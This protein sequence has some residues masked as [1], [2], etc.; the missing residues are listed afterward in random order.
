MMPYSRQ[1]V[2][3]EDISAVVDVLKSNFLTQ[4][5]MVSEFERGVA[6]YCGVEHAVATCNATAALHLAC[7]ALGVAQ[8]DVVWVAAT[9]FVASANCA[10][11]CGADI[12]FVDIDSR[13]GL[14]SVAALAAKFASYQQQGKPL[15]KV[16]IVVHIAG[17]SCDM[18]ALAALCEPLNIAII[19]DASH[20]LGG[21]YQRQGVGC[22]LYS[23]CSVFSFHPV[24]PIT[25]GEGGM[26]VSQDTQLIKKARLL[27]SHGIVKD[28]EHCLADKPG[29]WYYEQQQLGFNY[30]LSDIHAALGVS[31]LK[32]LDSFI[33]RKQILVQ[34]YNVAFQHSAI[35]PLLVQKDCSSAW[36]LYIVQFT[37]ISTRNRCFVALR[38]AGFG[39]NLHYLPIPGHPYYRNLGFSPDDYPNATRYAETSLSLPLFP[40]MDA[41]DVAKVAAICLQCDSS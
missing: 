12:D 30:R 39:V 38:A 24:K 9:S 28:A 41:A 5:P 29:E 10:L 15:P 4:G 25:S 3:D 20:A 11:Y 33:S 13:T 2:A 40:D 21:T 23:A 16:L 14:I 7:L 18:Q 31:Q 19:E 1:Q 26:L 34:Q 8:G 32:R 6:Q 36:H 22:C 37:D 35:Q 27:A 17:Q